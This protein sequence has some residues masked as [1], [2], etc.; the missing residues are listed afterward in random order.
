MVGVDVQQEDALE[1]VGALQVARADGRVVVVAEA[2]GLVGPG[3]VSGR[4]HQGETP[5]GPRGHDRVEQL[6]HAAHGEQRGILDLHRLGHRLALRLGHRAQRAHGADDVRVGVDQ[7]Q[8]ADA[9]LA[10]RQLAPAVGEVGIPQ[11]REQGPQALAA[12][13]AGD[14]LEVAAEAVVDDQQQG[15]AGLG[16]ATRLD[17]A[18]LVG[19]AQELLAPRQALR[20]LHQHGHRLARPGSV[21]RGAEALL[22]EERAGQPARFG[23]RPRVRIADLGRDE[24]AGLAADHEADLALDIGRQLLQAV[25]HGHD[26]AQEVPPGVVQVVDVGHDMVEAQGLVEVHRRGLGLHHQAAQA[27]L[28]ELP[29]Q[30]GAGQE[31]GAGAAVHPLAAPGPAGGPAPGGGQPLDL[32]GAAAM[33][34]GRLDAH[35]PHQTAVDRTAEQVPVLA[36]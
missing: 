10:R 33:F 25:G 1:A 6:E 11:H 29:Q 9:G 15:L 4:T 31:Q 26:V 23:V 22:E 8:L 30:P 24:G 2:H 7:A 28:V 32:H 12:L 14:L 17:Q 13:V 36:P 3:V 34:H 5:V 35:H 20:A 16:D 18:V 19:A 27:R 21:A